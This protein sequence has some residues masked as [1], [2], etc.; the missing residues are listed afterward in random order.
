[1]ENTKVGGWYQGK[2]AV[3]INVLRQPGANVVETVQRLKA[4][5]PRLAGILP[6]AVKLTTVH[7]KT[8][9]IQ[10]SIHDVQFTLILSVAL[11]TLVV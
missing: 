6:S 9:T 2:P 7:D 1:L 4:E 11:V 5:L 3:I 10:A 8:E